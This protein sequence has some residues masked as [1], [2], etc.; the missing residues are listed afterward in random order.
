MESVTL[1]KPL[2]NE[3][4]LGY[5]HFQGY[6]DGL[7]SGDWLDRLLSPWAECIE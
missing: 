5:L 6:V 3:D 4:G 1:Y 2:S 7:S